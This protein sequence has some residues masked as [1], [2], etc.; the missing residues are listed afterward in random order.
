[1]DSFLHKSLTLL[2]Y[3][4]K[5][6]ITKIQ[7]QGWFFCFKCWNLRL[8]GKCLTNNSQN[9]LMLIRHIMPGQRCVIIFWMKML[10]W[11]WSFCTSILCIL[12]ITLNTASSKLIKPLIYMS[13]KIDEKK[14]HFISSSMKLCHNCFMMHVP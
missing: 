4:F 1:M 6:F 9:N 12:Y 8:A 7:D 14:H 11:H 13:C 10:I 5:E 2:S 3:I